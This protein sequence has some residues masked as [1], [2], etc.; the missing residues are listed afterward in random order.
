MLLSNVISPRIVTTA[1]QIP[2]VVS[3]IQTEILT[4]VGQALVRLLRTKELVSQESVSKIG[5]QTVQRKF[6]RHKQKGG[7]LDLARI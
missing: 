4:A 2:T 5:L 7:A 3:S 6:T 1:A